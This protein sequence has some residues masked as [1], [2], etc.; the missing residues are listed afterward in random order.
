MSEP[1]KT[2]PS[3]DVLEHLRKIHPMLRERRNLE[4]P[5]ARFRREPQIF[6]ANVRFPRLRMALARVIGRAAWK[7]WG[8]WTAR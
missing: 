4:Q 1:A 3:Y 5:C 2:L 8:E 7:G 6:L